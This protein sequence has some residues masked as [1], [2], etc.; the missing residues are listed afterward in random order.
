MGT[1]DLALQPSLIVQYF[2][3]ASYYLQS[4]NCF[5]TEQVVVQLPLVQAAVE[6]L[7][8]HELALPA[9]WHKLQAEAQNKHHHP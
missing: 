7:P 3:G 1:V 8:D 5:R 6:C 9:A 4:H 2:L